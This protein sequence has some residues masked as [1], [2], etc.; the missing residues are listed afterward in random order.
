MFLKYFY[1]LML[2][3]I[4]K[5]KKKNI[6]FKNFTHFDLIWVMNPK[7]NAFCLTTGPSLPVHGCILNYDKICSGQLNLCGCH[8]IRCAYQIKYIW[9][10]L[11]LVAIENLHE[12]KY[13]AKNKVVGDE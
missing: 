4:L 1:M 8:R 5:K 10:Q 13:G 2:K 7:K 12:W 9:L 11:C 6:I 3:I